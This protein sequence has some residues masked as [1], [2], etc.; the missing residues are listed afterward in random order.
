MHTD[1]LRCAEAWCRTFKQLL[2]S[3]LRDHLVLPVETPD[4]LQAVLECC[5]MEQM[6]DTPE[7]L[8]IVDAFV[9]HA[10]HGEGDED[11]YDSDDDSELA[12]VG[13]V[14]IKDGASPVDPRLTH[15]F[16]TSKH[17]LDALKLAVNE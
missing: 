5:R 14:Q 16:E 11:L 7:L 13:L 15:I 17:L 1:L 3:L 10:L 4:M 9:Q 8:A 6:L 12:A 2:V